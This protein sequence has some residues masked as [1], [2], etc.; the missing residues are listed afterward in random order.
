M[1]AGY[2]TLMNLGKQY[3]GWHYLDEVTVQMHNIDR[4]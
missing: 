1:S 4:K 2:F 3:R